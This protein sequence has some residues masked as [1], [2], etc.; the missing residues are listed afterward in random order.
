MYVVES[1]PNNGAPEK[2]EML[3]QMDAVVPDASEGLEVILADRLEAV[4]T[5]PA[6]SAKGLDLT[7]TLSSRRDNT[8]LEDGRRRITSRFDVSMK[9]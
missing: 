2:L 7:L 1:T 5:T 4:L 6:Y 9:R 3:V 8:G